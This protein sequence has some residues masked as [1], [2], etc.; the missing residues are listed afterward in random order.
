MSCVN[1]VARQ[2]Q[3]LGGE[4]GD[5]RAGQIPGAAVRKDVL[6]RSGGCAVDIPGC[7]GLRLIDIPGRGSLGRIDIPGRGSLR[8]IDIPGRC[9]GRSLA[10]GGR[11]QSMMYL[12]RLSF[13]L[14]YYL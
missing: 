5:I 9:G 7:G 10:V 12:L 3:F 6:V 4:T 1:L 8:R 2:A 11:S 13:L 14:N